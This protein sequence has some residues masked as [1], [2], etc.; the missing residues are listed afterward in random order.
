MDINTLR[1]ATTLVSFV[2]FVGIIWW[3]MD[4]RKNQ[5]FQDAAELPLQDD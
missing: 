3:A 5:Q 4:R 2:T 1:I